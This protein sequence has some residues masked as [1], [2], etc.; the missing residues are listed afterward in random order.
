MIVGVAFGVVP[1]DRH[2]G[3]RKRSIVAAAHGVVPRTI[4]GDKREIITFCVLSEPLPEPGMRRGVEV[5]QMR[6]SVKGPTAY[7]IEIHIGRNTR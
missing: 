2:A 1:H 3:T 5:G 6:W 7:H 4:V